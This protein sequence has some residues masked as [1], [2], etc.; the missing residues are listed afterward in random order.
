MSIWMIIFYF[1]YVVDLGIEWFCELGSE[2]FLGFKIFR[3]G[4]VIRIIKSVK[5]VWFFKKCKFIVSV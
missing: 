3:V 4:K 2:F 1:F 5:I